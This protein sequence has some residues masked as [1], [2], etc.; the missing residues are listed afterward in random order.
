M[1]KSGSISLTIRRGAQAVFT[2]GLCLGVAK[3]EKTV[4]LLSAWDKFFRVEIWIL[5]KN[6]VEILKENLSGQTKKMLAEAETC[7]K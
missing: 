4:Y 7:G 3:K 6:R 5:E 2:Y 1:S